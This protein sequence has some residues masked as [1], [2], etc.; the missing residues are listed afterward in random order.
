MNNPAG[1][2][3]PT[4]L[5]DRSQF[6]E[7]NPSQSEA[8]RCLL[9]LDWWRFFC[10]CPVFQDTPA[11]L[12]VALWPV[13]AFPWKAQNAQGKRVFI[14]LARA[15]ILVTVQARHSQGT[16]NLEL[17]CQALGGDVTYFF[18]RHRPKHFS[19]QPRHYWKCRW[20][21]H[22]D[23]PDEERDF[24]LP[25]AVST[26]KQVVPWSSMQSLIP[27]LQRPTH[28]FNLSNMR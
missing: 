25:G 23:I 12:C 17:G 9:S 1:K 2:P 16:L 21:Q 7:K 6:T 28:V 19:T 10:F 8:E 27:V 15:T 3:M 24:T 26:I 18:Y 11:G 4:T 20:G 22:W 5:H 13:E 14:S